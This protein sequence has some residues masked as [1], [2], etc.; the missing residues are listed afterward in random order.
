MPRPQ[1][2]AEPALPPPLV[3]AENIEVISPDEARFTRGARAY[4]VRGLARALSAEALKV[5]LRLSLGERLHVDTLDLYQAR[6]RAGHRYGR[7]LPFR[8]D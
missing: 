3:A 8:V 5:T 1:P 2:T 6:G 7:R 4:R